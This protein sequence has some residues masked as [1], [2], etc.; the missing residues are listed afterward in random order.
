MSRISHGLFCSS[1]SFTTYGIVS[2]YIM[3]S[4]PPRLQQISKLFSR[5]L[6]EPRAQGIQ[7]GLP[8][9]GPVFNQNQK[10]LSSDV[11]DIGLLSSKLDAT[12]NEGQSCS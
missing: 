11:D 4:C 2:P 7:S 6:M 5:P 10:E 9:Q 12:F 3:S 8:N 1:K